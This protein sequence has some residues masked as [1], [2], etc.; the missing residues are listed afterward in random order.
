MRRKIV[1][2]LAVSAVTLMLA[3][4]AYAYTGSADGGNGGLGN[5][6]ETKA[7]AGVSTYSVKGKSHGLAPNGM[8]R[9]KEVSVYGTGTGTQFLNPNAPGTTTTNQFQSYGTT[10]YPNSGYTGYGMNATTNTDGYRGYGTNATGTN[11]GGYRGYSANTS[12]TNTDGYRGFGTNTSTTNTDGYRNYSTNNNSTFTDGNRMNN[13]RNY[14]TSNR[15]TDGRYRTTSTTTGNGSR[16]GWLG[17]LGL[18]GLF[19]VRSRNPQRD[20]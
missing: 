4:P 3:V 20:R 14:S 7:H 16:W 1:S 9:T 13:Y 17:L 19:G 6:M 11:M 2:G 12:T 5:G 15:T 8:T 18:L 10:T